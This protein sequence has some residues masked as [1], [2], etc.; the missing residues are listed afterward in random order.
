MP[1]YTYIQYYTII[2]KL[3]WSA[4]RTH[5]R[6]HLTI[7]SSIPNLLYSQSV[8]S[9]E[10]PTGRIVYFYCVGLLLFEYHIVNNKLPNII[11]VLWIHYLS[12]CYFPRIHLLIIIHHLKTDIHINYSLPNKS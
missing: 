11:L 8:K 7:K 9:E 4:E 1:L 5:H 6:V 3:E 10:Y 2:S 12:V